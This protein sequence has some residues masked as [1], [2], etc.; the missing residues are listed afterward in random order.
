MHA[1]DQK[2]WKGMGMEGWVARWYARTRRNDMEDFRREA[3]VV[4]E[5]LRSVCNVLEVAPGPGFF[6]I[7]LAKLEDFKITG[8]DVSRTLVEIAT[9]NARNAGVKIDFRLGNASAM[10]DGR[11]ARTPGCRPSS[12]QSRISYG[13]RNYPQAIPRR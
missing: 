12:D 4:A 7:E 8:L 10:R 11:M 2:A 9:E 6:A 3:K 5:H 1:G 13:A